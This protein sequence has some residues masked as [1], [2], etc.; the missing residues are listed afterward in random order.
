MIRASYFACSDIDDPRTKFVHYDCNQVAKMR[1]DLCVILCKIN[2]LIRASNLR[3]AKSTIVSAI[4]LVFIK[5][6]S[7]QAQRSF[8]QFPSIIRIRPILTHSFIPLLLITVYV[9]HGLIVN[10]VFNSI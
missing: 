1:L 5:N 4:V 8:G 9:D 6:A 10:I 7:H 2:L 3:A